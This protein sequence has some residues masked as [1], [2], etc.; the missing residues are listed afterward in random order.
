MMAGI[1]F[2]GLTPAQKD[3][4]VSILNDNGCD[5]SCGM[6]VAVCRRDDSKCTRSL[7]LGNQV[8]SL[9]K[10]GKT[11][12]EIVK[13]ALTP[14]SKFVQF[15]I[16]PGDAPATG[17]ANAKV[18]IIHYYDYQC[19]FCLRLVPVI[20]QIAKEYP[21]DVRIVYKMHPLSIHPNAP[22]AAEAAMAA[23]AQGKF[24]DMNK[25]LFAIQTALTR[26]NILAAA[27]AINLDMDRF[28]KD[29]DSNAYA[30]AIAA[31]AAESESIGASGTPASFVNGR[32]VSGAKQFDFF[33]QIIDEE[34]KWAQEGTRP[35]FTMGKNVSEASAPQSPTAAGPDPN[36]VY[37]IAAG[38]APV[39]GSAKAKV[40]ILHYLDYQ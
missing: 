38:K 22:I 14:P 7:A 9:V 35:K 34:L 29:I 13:I 39:R 10:Q 30:A 19:P 36:K 4:A 20:D 16:T 37:E 3:L 2:T 18:T 11:R 8:V 40:T 23:K 32:Y 1:D 21:N 6:K 27:K 24:F 12:D 25:A 5:C 26:D 33:K 28:T 31:E 17:P 15:P